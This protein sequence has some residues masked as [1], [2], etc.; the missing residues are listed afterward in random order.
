MSQ[1]KQNSIGEFD[2]E[3]IISLFGTEAAED[4]DLDRLKSFYVKN[5]T[6]KKIT[7]NIPIRILVGHKG[8][9]KSAIFTI[10]QH[11]DEQNNRLTVSLHPDDIHDLGKSGTDFHDM[12]RSW[13]EGLINVIASKVIDQ[14]GQ[15]SD[16]DTI[17]TGGKIIGKL[18]NFLA[19]TFKSAIDRKVSFD[20]S[21][22]AI[23]D[24][25]LGNNKIYVYIDD[26]DRG[27]EGRKED[28][29]RISALLNAIRDLTNANPGLYIRISLRSDVYYLV[30]TSDE[31][32]D[33]IEG[34]VVWHSW[35]HHEILLLLI[36]R[37]ESF[38]GREFNV[39]I[40]KN[41]PQHNLVHFLDPIFERRYHGR[42]R[43]Q[44][45][46][47]YKVLMSLI[48]K[49]PRD[50]VKL[51]TLAARH[52]ADNGRNKIA[53]DDIQAILVEYSHGRIQD[54]VNEY[55]SELSDI[56]RLL[57]SMKP[58]QAER[59]EGKGYIY[60]T[61]TLKLKLRNIIQQGDFF[62]AGRRKAQPKDLINFLYKINFITARKN[63]GDRIVRHYFEE[64]QYL[65]EQDF[66]YNWEIHPA[67]RWALS[68]DDPMQ[69]L[70]Q[71][72]ILDT[73]D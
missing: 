42:G 35:T 62:F 38:F 45:V 2:E 12:I 53:D 66:G 36:K 11:E 52:A 15:N 21:Y 27:W 17:K 56:H 73:E 1:Y 8:I 50:L 20:P 23:I 51:C 33:K 46:E 61:P 60:D 43:W 7:A 6:H 19:G 32:T 58:S 57:L 31:S 26:L 18:T 3:T 16:S 68:P 49:R 41:V 69:Q 72:E 39:E 64:A 24:N 48:R 10:A 63:V 25:Y 29:T 4:N 9:G 70:N 14:L 5:A 71:V 13:K 47:T 28:I 55:R 59:K 40:N 37:I 65:N 22:R 34:S 44:N 54:T 67:F 30:R